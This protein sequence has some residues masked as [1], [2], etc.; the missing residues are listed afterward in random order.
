MENIDNKFIPI[1]TQ[2]NI[3]DIHNIENIENIENNKCRVCFEN[4][5]EEDLFKPCLCSSK[6]HKSCLGQWRLLHL[7]HED[8]FLKCEICKFNYIIKN[9]NNNHTCFKC[10]NIINKNRL[11]FSIII[12]FI[13][14]FILTLIYNIFKNIDT[15]YFIKFSYEDDVRNYILSVGILLL[16]SIIILIINDIIF[17][18]K[19]KKNS[20]DYINKYYSNFAGIGMCRFIFSLG[21]NFIAYLVMPILGICITTMIIN[22]VSL[23]VFQVYINKNNIQLYEVLPFNSQI[24]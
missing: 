6:V 10:C 5:N 2:D 23:H 21:L 14:N 20:N 12:F 8:N 24:I 4:D 15:H 16:I 17:F 22:L 7:P 11:W 19:N 18:C 13:V 1:I 9:N 3:E